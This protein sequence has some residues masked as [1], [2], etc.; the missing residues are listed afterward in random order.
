MNAVLN[1]LD[2]VRTELQAAAGKTFDAGD[3]LAG[4]D[5]ADALDAPQGNGACVPR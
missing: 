4:I 3:P 1:R 5:L 2:D